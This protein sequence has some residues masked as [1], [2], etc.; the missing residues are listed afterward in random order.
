MTQPALSQEWIAQQMRD[1]GTSWSVGTFGAIAE[2]ARDPD[3]PARFEANRERSEV[4]TSRG[5][6]RIGGLTG[7]RAVAYETTNKD[8]ALWSHA[9]ALCLPIDACLM[10][11]RTTLTEIGLDAE[12]LR[13]SDREGILFDLGL[14]ALQID[15]CVR[16]S[17]PELLLRLREGL[18]RSV[19]DHANPAMPAILRASPHRVFVARLGRGEVYQAIP[20]PDQ[21]SPDGPHT[22][23]LPKLL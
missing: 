7:A 10:N 14:G 17:D 11:R 6:V 19:F 16:T 3:E 22:H 21:K 1:A 5:G 13:E 4:V 9:I 8:L 12:A 23:V 15:V 20:A 2:F 18:G